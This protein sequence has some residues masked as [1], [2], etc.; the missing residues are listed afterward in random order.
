MLNLKSRCET[1]FGRLYKLFNTCTL[2]E[3]LILIVSILILIISGF[4]LLNQVNRLI[5]TEIPA[6]GGVLSEGLI[7]S[8]RF[9]NPLLEL[10]DSDRDLSYLIY[11][12][13]M[14][15]TADGKLIPDLAKNYSISPDGLTYTFELKDNIYFHDGEKVTTDDIEYTIDMAQNVALRSPKRT[16]WTGITINKISNKKIS[17]IL[18]QP[19]SPFLENTTIG[20]LPKHIWSSATV[21]EFPF[22]PFNIDAVGSGPYKIKQINRNGSGI[23]TSFEM[24]AFNRYAL[25]EP[26]ITNLV[27]RFYNNEKALNDALI[28]GEVESTSTLSPQTLDELK[29]KIDNINERV[30]LPRIFGLF[31]NQNQNKIFLN[32]EVRQALSLTVDKD[33]IVREVLD[34]YGETINSPIPTGILATIGSASTTTFNKDQAL[35]E[36]KAILS[37]AGWKFNETTKVWEK[38]IN[39]NEKQNLAFSISTS[40]ADDLKKTAE[41]LKQ[42]WAELGA[43]VEIQTFDQSD[44][45]QTVIASRNYDSLLF[46]QVVGRSLDLFA[47]WHS[48]QR[49]T[50]YNVA[51]YTNSKVDKLLED[52]RQTTDLDKRIKDYSLFQTEIKNDVPAIFIYS[53]QFIYSLPDKIKGFDS[54][55]IN[56]RSERFE[57]I[58]RWYIETDN[59]WKFLTNLN[60]IKNL[61]KI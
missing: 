11:S 37:K 20:I 4:G 8:P 21:E 35:T 7:G 19:Y 24:T 2:T 56:N 36:A 48:S 43:Q 60:F 9:I 15:A 26:Y 41:I 44:L 47:F 10:S 16:N 23:P 22:S 51:L 52:S 59:V 39:K 61:I 57:Q 6:K 45:N 38:T 58:N 1:S 54:G 55:L 30:S 50:G 29:N 27:L 33:R 13:L 14:K 5:T 18:K 12:G 42:T 40:N 28:S 53:P 17:F 34:G 32:K 3:K 25:G 46:G 49:L 31:F